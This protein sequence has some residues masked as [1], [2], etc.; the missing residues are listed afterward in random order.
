[1]QKI[2]QGLTDTVKSVTIAGG[3]MILAEPGWSDMDWQRTV[4]ELGFQD[5]EVHEQDM[6]MLSS[7]HLFW[8]VKP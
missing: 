4:Y 5:H 8:W 3:M 7:G 1:M 2:D 6:G